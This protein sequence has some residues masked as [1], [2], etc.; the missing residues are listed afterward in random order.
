MRNAVS[1]V[2]EAVSWA[3]DHYAR[4]VKAERRRAHEELV[5]QRKAEFEHTKR[6]KD[7]RRI[8]DML[9]NL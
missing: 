4:H 7:S 9:A 2:E 5:N 1:Y 6:N 8:N 3:N